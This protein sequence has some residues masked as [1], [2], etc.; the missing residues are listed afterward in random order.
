VLILLIFS[1]VIY[2]YF[3]TPPDEQNSEE[4]QDQ[5]I[6]TNENVNQN[7]A[8]N[9]NNN[10]SA[11]NNQ[12]QLNTLETPQQN[13]NQQTAPPPQQNQQ[14]Q[15]NNNQN[16]QTAE[17]QPN[18]EQQSK[19]EQQSQ[20][21]SQKETNS[22]GNKTESTQP[23]TQQSSPQNIPGVTKSSMGWMDEQNK[24][25]YI[26]LENGKFTIQE[27]AWDS[28]A[29]ANKRISTLA[30]LIPGLK[31]SVVAA[32]LGS[33]G[34]WYRARIGE[35]STLE[36]AKKTAEQLRN[37]EKGKLQALIYSFFWVA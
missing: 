28:D 36:E 9:E 3:F 13:Q 27:S 37:K 15:P 22:A 2:R 1:P 4:I 11:S 17:Q 31:G 26:Q 8:S 24:V 12:A 6:N 7:T 16:Q 23:P 34:T 10:T 29:K 14:S 18:Q 21:N 30:S 32:D 19:Q 5:G 35:F 20:P 33:K 25:I